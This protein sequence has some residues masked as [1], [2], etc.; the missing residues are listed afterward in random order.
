[1]IGRVRLPHKRIVQGKDSGTRDGDDGD[2][3]GQNSDMNRIKPNEAVKKKD[4]HCAKIRRCQACEI[5]MRNDEARED[6]EEI[7]AEITVGKER[8]KRIE[9]GWYILLCVHPQHQ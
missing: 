4:L 6:E 9:T 7:N 1:E 3:D 5:D 8:Q 2:K